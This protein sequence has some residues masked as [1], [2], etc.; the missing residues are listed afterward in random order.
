MEIISKTFRT[1]ETQI[2]GNR[3][4]KKKILAGGHMHTKVNVIPLNTD[5]SCFNVIDKPTSITSK[6]IETG[7]IN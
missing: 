2:Q 6:N 4:P 3:S 7:I 5:L 1:R